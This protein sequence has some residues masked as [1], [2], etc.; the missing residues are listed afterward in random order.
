MAGRSSHKYLEWKHNCS[1]FRI[2]GLDNFS[3]IPKEKLQR[4]VPKNDTKY[5]LRL[6]TNLIINANKIA[7]IIVNAPNIVYVEWKKKSAP[8]NWLKQRS[9]AYNN[10]VWVEWTIECVENLNGERWCAMN[11]NEICK[12]ATNGEYDHRFY[13]VSIEHWIELIEK[14]WSWMYTVDF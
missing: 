13:A 9:N 7:V 4:L 14:R 5:K 2:T 10:F 1:I 6:P 11:S 12:P 3:H 8:Y